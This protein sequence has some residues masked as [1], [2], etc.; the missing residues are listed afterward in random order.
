MTTDTQL[1]DSARRAWQNWQHARSRVSRLEQFKH[2][3]SAMKADLRL[4][5]RREGDYYSILVE[6]LG[7]KPV[8]K[9]PSPSD[10]QRVG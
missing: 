5:R 10:E 1:L 2:L 3:S 6:I 9:A 4:W 8:A 7:P